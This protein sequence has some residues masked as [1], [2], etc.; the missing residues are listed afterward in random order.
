MKLSKAQKIT[1]AFY[2]KSTPANFVVALFMAALAT[3]MI[4]AFLVFISVFAIGL[5]VLGIPF[6]ITTLIAISLTK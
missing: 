2:V 4:D 5:V 3:T 6:L 1:L